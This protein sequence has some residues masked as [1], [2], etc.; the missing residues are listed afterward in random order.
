MRTCSIS[1]VLKHNIVLAQCYLFRISMLRYILKTLL[2]LTLLAMRCA[3][4]ME[5]RVRR[6]DHKRDYGDKE[7]RHRRTC[8]DNSPNYRPSRHIPSTDFGV[9]GCQPRREKSLPFLWFFPT[10]YLVLL[11]LSLPN[12]C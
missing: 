5:L 12:I 1:F 7:M 10:D 9:S 4:D 8:K 3:R 6:E 2:T 11:P